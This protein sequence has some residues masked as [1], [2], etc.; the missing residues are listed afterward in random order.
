ML[1]QVRN[2]KQ[3]WFSFYHKSFYLSIKFSFRIQPYIMLELHHANQMLQPCCRSKWKLDT[4]LCIYIY[5]LSVYCMTCTQ[6]HP[7][8]LL[9]RQHSVP[10][11]EKGWGIVRIPLFIGGG[12]ARW[13]KVKVWYRGRDFSYL[14]FSRF[15]FFVFRNYFTFCKIVLYTWK[16]IFFSAAKI[17]CIK[18]L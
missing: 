10:D 18:S 16:K 7:L 17:L 3:F 2:F 9:G 14:I 8:F 15:I 1:E 5:F 12:R 13:W 6:C 11:F 4:F